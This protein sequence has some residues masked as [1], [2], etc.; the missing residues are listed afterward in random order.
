MYDF[1]KGKLIDASPLK[2]TL[3]TNNIGY[4][5]FIPLRC[6]ANLPPLNSDIICFL[7]LVIREDSH[8]L[9]GFITKQERDLFETLITVSGVGPKTA[10]ALLGHLEVDQFYNAISSANTVLL[11]KVP[12][13]G[14]KTGERLIIELR[15]KI[16]ILEKDL[17]KVPVS[18][19][20]DTCFS[21]ALSAL[22]HLGYNHFQAQK[23]LKLA[24][25]ENK[26]VKDPGKLIAL[27]LKKI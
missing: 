18:S 10:L 8:T 7:S 16:K 11:G 6:S 26:E 12:G 22:I 15:D 20:T 9:Y 2:I 24:V 25:D 5:I 17:S 3:E 23:A 21:D 19:K 14:K 13:I 1:I 27:A 4:K